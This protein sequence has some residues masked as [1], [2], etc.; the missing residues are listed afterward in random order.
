MFIVLHQPD[1]SGDAHLLAEQ[2]F[3]KEVWLRAV[4]TS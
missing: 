4:L 1:N 3:L 2:Q